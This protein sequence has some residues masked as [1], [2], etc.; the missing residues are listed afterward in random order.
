VLTYLAGAFRAG[1]QPEDDVGQL[2]A[3]ETARTDL[4]NGNRPRTRVT[5]A[6]M[7]VLSFLI[8]HA[9]AYETYQRVIPGGSAFLKDPPSVFRAMGADVVSFVLP[10]PTLWWRG[11]LHPGQRL[12]NLWGDSSN[13]YWNYVGLGCLVLACAGAIMSRQHRLTWPLLA[14]AIIALVLSLGPSL[15]FA[16]VRPLPAPGQP[17]NLYFM[18][19]GQAV[20]GLPTAPLF[21]HLP[22]VDVMRA[23]YRWFG[24][25]RLVLILFAAVGVQRL[26]A[27]AGATR[28]GHPAHRRRRQAAVGVLVLFSVLELLPAPGRIVAQYQVVDRYRRDL[29]Q[30]AASLDDA[31][32]SAARVVFAPLLAPGVY[33]NDYL[34]AYLVPLGHYRSYNVAGDKS[35]NRLLQV[36]P[37]DIRNLILG[38]S[39]VSSAKHA[40]AA[41][42]VDAVVV[43]NFDLRLL[44]AQWP[45][46]AGF[47]KLGQKLA[48]QFAADPALT[49]KRYYSF[50]IVTPAT[51]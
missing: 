10:S 37:S 22:G 39:P 38:K 46:P 43:P 23:T 15:K 42:S 17:E 32:P 25:T 51:R 36:W 28:S 48:N 19:A 34:S 18:N 3:T 41:G 47:R 45:S 35:V 5:I 8:A 7:R 14:A 26:F 20:F 24:A 11:Q 1:S 40:F 31:L 9:V 50:A 12:Y 44:P 21:A 13:S 2:P 27:G 6:G 30:L 16:D 4:A 29:K 33:P 49:V